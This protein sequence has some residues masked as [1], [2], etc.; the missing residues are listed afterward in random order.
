MAALRRSRSQSNISRTDGACVRP[1]RCRCDVDD[2]ANII[3]RT[4]VRASVVI[5]IR[6]HATAGHHN[7]TFHLIRS[8]DSIP[9]LVARSKS[10]RSQSRRASRGSAATPDGRER[11]RER[12]LGVVSR[13]A[14]GGGGE[15]RMIFCRV[16]RH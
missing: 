9:A 4:S 2:S 6:H 8:I 14:A 16:A 11:K 12:G 13:R 3:S 1:P 15:M 5:L 10:V 7:R